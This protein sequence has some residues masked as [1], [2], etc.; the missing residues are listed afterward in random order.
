MSETVNTTAAPA[1]EQAAHKFG[2]EI[3]NSVY[4]HNCIYVYLPIQYAPLLAPGLRLQEQKTHAPHVLLA[5]MPGDEK[6]FF[7]DLVF[8]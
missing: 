2:Q 3:K 7:H 8:A 6:P 1:A 5:L 4:Y